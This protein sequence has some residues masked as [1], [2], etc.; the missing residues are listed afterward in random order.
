ML[1]RSEFVEINS[2]SSTVYEVDPVSF[3]YKVQ[4]STR[5]SS[6]EWYYDY[7]TAQMRW[8]QYGCRVI[9]NTPTV[10]TI[11]NP[12]IGEQRYRL[13]WL[14]AGS[15]MRHLEYYVNTNMPDE[16]DSYSNIIEA[17]RV[18]LIYQGIITSDFHG[19]LAYTEGWNARSGGT[20][21]E[22]KFDTQQELYTIWDAELK[23]AANKFKT[24]TNQK[25]MVGYDMAYN[26]DAQG[27][28]KAAN[29]LRLRIALR[30]MKRDMTKAKQIA[31][32]VLAA[33]ADIPAK[34]DDSFVFWLEGKYSENGDY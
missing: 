14:D 25:S 7:Y 33:T 26:G 9:G 4:T 32:E 15:Y 5:S 18:S 22:P 11:W 19:S 34:N 30:L 21:T 31:S 20:V 17:A 10:Y 2:N 28:V 24:N 16:A 12:N 29:A 23:T 1:F 27:W 8:M 13:C 3:L 6:W